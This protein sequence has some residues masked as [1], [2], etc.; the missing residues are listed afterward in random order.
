MGDS[1]TCWDNFLLWELSAIGM[2]PCRQK[3]PSWWL[4]FVVQIHPRLTCV[5][6]ELTAIGRFMERIAPELVAGTEG[7]TKRPESFVPVFFP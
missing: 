4:I 6:D 2:Y 3:G 5:S 7:Q 1:R